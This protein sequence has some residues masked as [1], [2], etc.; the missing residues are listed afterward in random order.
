MVFNSHFTHEA[1]LVLLCKLLYHRRLHSFD[2]YLKEIDFTLNVIR[3][4]YRL[5]GFRLVIFWIAFLPQAHSAR[6][7]GIR[8]MVQNRRAGLVRHGTVVERNARQSRRI[9]LQYTKRDRVGL[10]SNDARLRIPFLEIEDRYPDVASTID[11]ER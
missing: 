11:N 6:P 10:E 8:V 1:E 9:F 5:Y 7:W 4:K 3:Q 2:I